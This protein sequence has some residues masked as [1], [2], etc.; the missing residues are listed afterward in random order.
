MHR[1][2]LNPFNHCF[3][4]RIEFIAPV[5][6]VRGNLS[7]RQDL[8]YAE[9]NN[10]AYESPAGSVNY[11]RNYT[12][13]YIGAKI[14]ASGAKIF[15]VRTKNA[16]NMSPKAIKA[17]ALLGGTGAIVGAILANKSEAPYVN[18]Y[19]QWL[20]LKNLGSTDSFRKTLSAWV[21]RALVNKSQNINFTGPRPLTTI[22]NP[23]YDG[24][25]TTGAVIS[26]AVLA[27]FWMQLA[28]NA[29]EFTINGAKGYAQNG[30]SFD[31]LISGTGSSVNV[32]G[33]TKD[34]E[35]VKYQE[36]FVIDAQG[37]YVEPAMN[38]TPNYAY[39]TTPDEP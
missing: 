18:A 27:Q 11:A 9:N 21:R 4:K 31:T 6:A 16:V 20:E 1:K 2:S 10:K 28:T 17:M 14:A 35:N 8:R 25:Q 32:L 15:S 22:K 39:G 13:R 7:G 26:Q 33:L 5:E 29:I 38:V 23:W 12:P 19:A 34:D 24:S 37:G 36:E 30:W 3:M